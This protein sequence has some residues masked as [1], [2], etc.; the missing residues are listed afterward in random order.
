MFI[1][2]R[3]RAAVGLEAGVSR[4]HYTPLSIKYPSYHSL[5]PRNACT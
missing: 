4:S 3:S 1:Q 2:N 5:K